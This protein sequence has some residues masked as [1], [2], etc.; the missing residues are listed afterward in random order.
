MRLEIKTLLGG[1]GYVLEEGRQPEESLLFID[2]RTKEG[3]CPCMS[4]LASAQGLS[5]LRDSPF[6]F[7]KKELCDIA[8][9]TC[10]FYELYFS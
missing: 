9:P 1:E 3:G 2:A 8:S 7:P 6:P 10:H 4:F 5:T